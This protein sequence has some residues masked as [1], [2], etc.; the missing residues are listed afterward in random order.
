[1]EEVGEFINQVGIVPAIVVG[2]FF[3]LE[4]RIRALTKAV[5][6]LCNLS[7]EHL[8]ATLRTRAQNGGVLDDEKDLLAKLE[9]HAPDVGLG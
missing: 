9:E 2:L 5:V 3:L 7:Q 6:T 8:K 1:M 4:V